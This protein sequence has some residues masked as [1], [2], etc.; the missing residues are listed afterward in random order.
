MGVV[1]IG[2]A[3]SIIGHDPSATLVKDGEVLGAIEEERLSREKHRPGIFPRRS[4]P[5]LLKEHSLSEDDIDE[6]AYYWDQRP[7]LFAMAFS[8]LRYAGGGHL[9]QALT[10][11]KDKLIG[12]L[13]YVTAPKMYLRVLLR[14]GN[15]PPLKYVD[16]HLAHAASVHL[17]SPFETSASAVFDG[18]GGMPCTSLYHYQGA[19]PALLRATNYPHSLGHAYAAVTEY[20]G[21]HCM[22]DEWKVMGLAPYGS[23]DSKLKAFFDELIVLLPD[24][25]YAIDP[26]LAGWAL[27][28][29]RLP[30]LSPRAGERLDGHPRE[31][32]L[33]PGQ[34]EADIALNFQ[35]RI[36]EVM[37]HVLRHLQ[38]QTGEKRLTLS[39]G[40]ALNCK[41][42]GKI[43]QNTDFEEIWLQPASHDAGASMGAALHRW[44]EI[45]DFEAPRWRMKHPYLGPAYG[46]EQIRME[47]DRFRLRYTETDDPAS[48]AAGFLAAG[49]V[50]GWFQGRMEWG[51]RALGNRSI[52]ADARKAEMKDRVNAAVKFREPFRPFAP[53]IPIERVAEYFEQAPPSPFMTFTAMIRPE[54]RAELGAVC[55][56]D[57]SGRLQSVEREANPL[58]HDL[59]TKFGELTGTPVVLNTSFNVKGEPIVCTPQEAIRTFCATGLDALV[60]DRFV[61]QKGAL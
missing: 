10:T 29:A 17:V 49:K 2:I 7:Y 35:N 1:I 23:V 34:R 25:D 43:L 26:K 45:N 39:G 53:A 14:R 9:R 51:P 55:H 52:L 20:L 22:A 40:V 8:T 11:T 15:P 3:G 33:D 41:A 21:F 36:E 48:A 56:K 42:N 5:F 30:A 16:H 61:L 6:V 54:K 27:T 59:I 44:Q 4:L 50:I 18:S 38:K 37:F 57:G 31:Y 58:F 47:L 13:S 12:G 46:P 24:G 19:R 28:Y 32:G 60:L